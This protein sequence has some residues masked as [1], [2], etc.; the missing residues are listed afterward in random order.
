[1]SNEEP[2][3]IV[4]L[5]SVVGASVTLVFWALLSEGCIL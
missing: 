3:T 2:S 1:M 4:A 5:C